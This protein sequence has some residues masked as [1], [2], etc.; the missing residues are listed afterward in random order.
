MASKNA[1]VRMPV[2]APSATAAARSSRGRPRSRGRAIGRRIS[3]ANA[4][5]S[6]TVP[7]A[8]TRSNSGSDSA[9]PSWIVVIDATASAM[10][11][12]RAA[13]GSGRVGALSTPAG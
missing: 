10:P 9:A 1:R 8:P 2:H 12:A 7:D 3:A 5:R 11:G 6:A 4:S 13:A